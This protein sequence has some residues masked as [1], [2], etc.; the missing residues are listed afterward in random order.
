MKQKFVSALLFLLSISNI[1]PLSFLTKEKSS[2]HNLEILFE[3]IRKKTFSLGWRNAARF[4]QG[5]ETVI[6]VKTSEGRQSNVSGQR[7][8]DSV[9]LI[10]NE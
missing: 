1:L 8:L 4:I 7:V 2:F 6:S 3:K 5:T 9:F 10:W